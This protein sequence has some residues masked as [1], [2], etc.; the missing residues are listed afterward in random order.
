MKK[1]LASILSFSLSFSIT[2]AA[3]N[4]SF[5]FRDPSD[6]HVSGS[7]DGTTDVL[8]MVGGYKENGSNT[9]T[10]D[11]SGNAAT[12]SSATQLASDPTACTGNDKVSDIAA[13]GTLTCTAD[14]DTDTFVTNKDLHDHLGGDGAQIQHSSLGGVGANDHHTPTVDTNAGTICAA[15]E[16]LD[17]DGTCKIAGGGSGH[18]ISTT[19]AADTDGSD[20][21]QRGTLAFDSNFFTGEDN[22]AQDQTFISLNQNLG[23]E[24][25]IKV[26]E[27]TITN[28]AA[29]FGFSGLD[30]NAIYKV[31]FTMD[32]DHTPTSATSD[33]PILRF[34]GDLSAVY[35]HAAQ[36]ASAGATSCSGSQIITTGIAMS[37][38]G[39]TTAGDGTVSGEFTMMKDNA[40]SMD[41]WGHVQQDSHWGGGDYVTNNPFTGDYAGGDVTSLT[42]D[43]S[44]QTLVYGHAKLF[45]LAPM[46]VG[47]AISVPASSSTIIND[48]SPSA[49]DH[50]LVFNC[51][52]GS[53]VTLTTAGGDILVDVVGSWY[54]ANGGDQNAYAN[55]LLDGQTHP[56]FT[57]NTD[58]GITRGAQFH[59]VD[60]AGNT[61]N[62]STINGGL[63]FKDV[64]AGE[65][66][67]CFSLYSSADASRF[68]QLKVTAREIRNVAGTGDVA[69]NGNNSFT[70]DNS[71]DETCPSGFTEVTAQSRTLGCIENDENASGTLTY[72]A[73][74]DDC[75]DEFG[76]TLPSYAEWYAAMA[77]YALTNETDD[78]E[79]MKDSYSGA[80]TICGSGGITTCSNG[81]I[82]S[83]T[84]AYRC[85]IPAA[86]LLVK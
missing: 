4:P 51:V 44:G 43:L 70:G 67:A 9:L 60:S 27:D 46:A 37:C 65:H 13:D 55:I 20:F 86:S 7:I 48:F 47:A 62:D 38:N 10:N 2:W 68:P 25:W 30:P 26:D 19:T 16:Y 32:T 69:S 33:Y 64:A 78:Y 72:V 24:T 53:T 73:A 81:A 85:W 1:I 12:A 82:A 8:D 75:F 50:N 28:S 58:A 34:N 71:F 40:G 22:A 21:T 79:W 15:G 14:V 39:L 83:G 36:T 29:G 52:S 63:L 59:L 31:V 18:T 57:N 42:I 45:K 66:S 74:V 76:G 6:N 5:E 3:Q 84:Q 35:R 77:N 54:D 80:S 11:I 61:V 56:G 17:G 49:V 41:V 23:S